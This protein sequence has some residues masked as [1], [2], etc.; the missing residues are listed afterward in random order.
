MS[1]NNVCITYDNVSCTCEGRTHIK[2][3][4]Q[5]FMKNEVRTQNNNFWRGMFKKQTSLKITG[6]IAK[7]FS[8]SL[9]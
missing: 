4:H 5:G 2:Y 9:E 7:D 6:V 1:H 8:G 3:S